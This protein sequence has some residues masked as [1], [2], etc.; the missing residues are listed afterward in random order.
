M[1]SDGA[2]TRTFGQSV[3]RAPE[4]KPARQ[5]IILVRLKQGLTK[6]VV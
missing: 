4:C 5:R 1:L 3:I 2:L 6:C